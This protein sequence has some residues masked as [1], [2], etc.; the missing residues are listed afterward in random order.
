MHNSSSASLFPLTLAAFE[1]YMLMDDRPGYPMVFPVRMR[2]A[3]RIDRPALEAALAETLPSHPLLCAVV[4]NSPRGKPVWVLPQKNFPNVFWAAQDNGSSKERGCGMDIRSE[5]GFRLWGR[6]ENDTTELT[7]QFHDACCDGVGALGLIGHLLAVYSTKTVAIGQAASLLPSDPASLL[8]REST[9]SPAS[10][11]GGASSPQ[12][13]LR[14]IGDGL[15]DAVRWVTHRPAVLGSDCTEAM[16]PAEIATVEGIVFHRFNREETAC[17]RNAKTR[18]KATL[19]DLCLRDLFLT[20]RDWTAAHPTANRKPWLRIAIP[21]NLRAGDAPRLSA[22]NGVSY[23]FVTRHPA[24]CADPMRLLRG[25]PRETNLAVRRRRSAMFLRVFRWIDR[26]PGAMSLYMNAD[27]CLASAVLSNIG[28]IER[29]LGAAFPKEAG[30]IVAGN[31]V[32]EEIA[33]APPIRPNTRASFMVGEYDKRLWIAL[34]TDPHFFARED[35]SRLLDRYVA[36]LRCT[37]DSIEA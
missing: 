32:L 14:R 5:P 6:Q 17:L 33:A 8:F 27:R 24:Q 9:A 22:A 16:P 1:K 28:D 23:T 4:E 20:L 26:I 21:V 12:H 18:A 13:R 2:F 29:H 36:R 34:R 7:F 10:S 25:I 30:K 19:N 3:G 31:L 11:E 37:I 15:R 35:A